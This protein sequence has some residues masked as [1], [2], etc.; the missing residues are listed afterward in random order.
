MGVDGVVVTIH[1]VGV[2][3]PDYGSDFINKVREISRK[4]LLFFPIYW[5]DITEPRQQQLLHQSKKLKWSISRRLLVS[6][7]GDAINYQPTVSDVDVYKRIHERVSI[8]LSQIYDLG[9]D[10]PVYI[11][12]H[13]LGSVI[14]SNF[15][16]DCQ[17]STSLGTKIFKP[18]DKALEVIKRIKTLVTMGS[19]LAVWSLKYPNGG[20]PISL[21]EGAR[22]LNLYSKSD[23]V[24]F[25]IKSINS[26][27]ES[28]S[29]IEDVEI[30]VGNL[31]TSWN[32]SCHTKYWE[33]ERV[34][35]ILV[36]SMV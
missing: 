13:S 24:S 10:L 16:W 17:N 36:E 1:G 35:E 7:A 8:T 9:E 6:F 15:I 4:D 3:G 21:P 29:Y 31:L 26:R 20:S 14:I 22:W 27:Y 2:Q 23:I 30:K 32:P 18:G 28:C 19:P 12:A 33:S 25:P 11:V 34:A 5:Q